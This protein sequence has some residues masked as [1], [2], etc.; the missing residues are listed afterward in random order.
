MVLA[1]KPVMAAFLLSRRLVR[2]VRD[3]GDIGNNG[4]LEAAVDYGAPDS[5]QPVTAARRS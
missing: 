1:R 4:G 5:C 3:G 2:V